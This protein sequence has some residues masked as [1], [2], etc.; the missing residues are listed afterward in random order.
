VWDKHEGFLRENGR[1]EAD[2]KAQTKRVCE[3]KIPKIC[4]GGY[5]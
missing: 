4:E 2:K 5:Y 3:L 1:K